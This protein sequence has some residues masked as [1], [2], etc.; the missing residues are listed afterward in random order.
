MSSEERDPKQPGGHSMLGRLRG[1]FQS[2]TGDDE[3]KTEEETPTDEA[4]ESSIPQATP[5]EESPTK[6]DSSPPVATPVSSNPV[7]SDVPMAQPLNLPDTL[8][9]GDLDEE[10]D[11]IPQASPI[12]QTPIEESPVEEPS[13]VAETSDIPCTVCGSLCAVGASSCPD[14]G[15]VFPAGGLQ[16]PPE[17]T[18]SSS[19][20]Q[21]QPTPVNLSEAPPPVQGDPAPSS[22]IKVRLKNRFELGQLFSER[23]EVKRYRGRDLGITGNE[24]AL[25]IILEQVIK[26]QERDSSSEVE[27]T[28]GATTLDDDDAFDDFMPTFDDPESILNQDASPGSQTEE[29]PLPPTW[30]NL[31]WERH[32]LEAVEHPGLPMVIDS[33]V[34]NN[35]EYLILE[36]PTGTSLW[37]AWDDPDATNEYRFNLLAQLAENLQMLHRVGALLEGIQPGIVVVDDEG[38]VR[39]SE[40]T[41]L[42][43]LPIPADAPLRGTN[44]TAPEMLSSPGKADARADLYSF[45]GLIYALQVGREL[46]DVDFESPGS[47]KPYIPQFPDC[48]PML[49]R[50]MT[51]TF[52]REVDSRFP[53]DEASKEDKTGMSELITVLKTCARILDDVH[54]EIGAWTNTGIVRS[55]NEDA[56]SLIHSCESRQDDFSEKA[57]ILLAD[58]MGGYEAGEVAAAMALTEVRRTL[59]ELP[60]FRALAGESG[61][62]SDTPNAEGNA[63]QPIDTEEMKKLIR[64]ALIAANKRVHDESKANPSRRGMGC[65]L[66]IVYLDSRNI[67]VG[68]VGDSRTYHLN[69]GAL[70]QLT[71]DQTLVNR[72]VELGQLTEEEAEK[73]PRR[74]ELQQALGG[75][76]TVD[77]GIYEAK[78]KPGD[79]VMVCSDGLINHVD[80]RTIR[81]FLLEESF[82]AEIAARRLVNLSNINGATDNTTVVVVRCT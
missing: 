71:R 80:N 79:V 54:L 42:L 15:Y 55:G 18:E 19:A 2:L 78:L 44:Y 72:L 43:P 22:S 33:F 49:G 27:V 59:C 23:L 82:S 37:D 47:P 9:D 58:G 13:E 45:G 53:T 20:P 73:H 35:H 34:D 30:P 29:L 66:E 16:A 70:N 32:I 41:D 64:D 81:Q 56:F 14:C 50:L 26:N 57:L 63:S 21:A 25:V 39:I 5:V 1:M 65:T 36:V 24:N 60:Q 17:P 69:D 4:E 31:A 51:R 62:D 6:D 52:R 77:P 68:H 40:L 76:P 74:N 3:P 75:Q 48:H 8:D 10:E 38:Q 12:E 61:F 46:S 7:E 11:L 28:P 67:I